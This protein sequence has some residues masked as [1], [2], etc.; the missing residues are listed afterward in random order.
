MEAKVIKLQEQIK[1]EKAASK[2]CTTRVKTLEKNL[3]NLGSK[4]NEKKSNKKLIEEKDKLI[5]T[6]QKKLKCSTTGHPQTKEIM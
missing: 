2:G 3:V 4:P 1:R 6:L 5:E